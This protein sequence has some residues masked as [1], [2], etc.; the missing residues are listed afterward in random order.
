[1]SAEPQPSH[2]QPTAVVVPQPSLDAFLPPEMAAPVGGVII[3]ALG[4]FYCATIVYVIILGLL[5]Y[6]STGRASGAGQVVAHLEDRR[7]SGAAHGE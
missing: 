2:P 1:M 7:I 6:R 3:A 5:N 4:F